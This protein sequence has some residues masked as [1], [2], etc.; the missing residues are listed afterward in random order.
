MSEETEDFY[1]RKAERMDNQFS[2]SRMPQS[3]LE[4]RDKFLEELEEGKILDVG[5]GTGRDVEYFIEQGF[6]ALGIDSAQGM[7]E[8]ARRNRKGEFIQKDMLEMEF[9]EDSFDGI[10][11]CASI[12]FLPY[13]DMKKVL[14]NFQEILSPEG[15]LFVS[16][17]K[18]R[19]KEK[20]AIWGERITQYC[21]SEEEATKLLENKGFQINSSE[22]HEDAPT[23]F[24][25]FICQAKKT[26]KN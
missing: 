21:L 7:I 5:C 14:E 4:I 26:S 2:E 18:G 13:E 8:R 20:K 11:C 6:E 3:F 22:T 15:S 19:G 16:F 25:N 1:S 23:T 24:M 12:F 10:W 17:R 9:K